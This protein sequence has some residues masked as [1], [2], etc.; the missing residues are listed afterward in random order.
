MAASRFNDTEFFD[1][2]VEGKVKE[3]Q[4]LCEDANIP[5]FMCFC[6]ENN[7]KKTKYKNYIHGAL[8]SGILLTDD[9]ITG[10]IG[11]ANGF[12]TV[13]GTTGGPSIEEMIDKAEN[14]G[15]MIEKTEGKEESVIEDEEDTGFDDEG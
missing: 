14:E 9:R 3:I 11:V 12:K 8:S 2:V 13:P 5:F 10:H 1:E 15:K 6:V 7:E 4:K